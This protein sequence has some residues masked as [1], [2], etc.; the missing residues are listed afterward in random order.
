MSRR[1]ARSQTAHQPYTPPVR[2]KR[3]NGCNGC[4]FVTVLLLITAGV[5][6]A[7]FLPRDI[8]DQI[9][10]QVSRESGL[11]QQIESQIGQSLP[12]AIGELPAGVITLTDADINTYIAANPSQFEPLEAVTVQFVPGAIQ[13]NLSAMGM[14]SQL[15]TGVTVEAGQIRLV[16]PRLDGPLSA[17]IAVDELVNRLEPQLNQHLLAQAHTIRDIRIEAGQLIAVV[18]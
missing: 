7:L 15:T 4:L 10:Q 1:A 12:A 9:G 8:L 16:N 11:Q 5:L 17:M 18:E 3:R 6:T 14:Q 2:R 13:A